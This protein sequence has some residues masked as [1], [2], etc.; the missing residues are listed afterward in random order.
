MCQKQ[1]ERGQTLAE[2]TKQSGHEISMKS[3][4]LS[5]TRMYF[6]KVVILFWNVFVIAFRVTLCL[7]SDNSLIWVSLTK[8]ELACGVG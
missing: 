2:L 4:K 8:T 7:I 6:T 5:T 3:D 1:V